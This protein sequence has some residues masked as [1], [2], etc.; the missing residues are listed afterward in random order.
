M[1]GIGIIGCG[2]ISQVR[3]IPEYFANPNAKIIG[4]FDLAKE[5]AAQMAAKYGGK[6]FDTVEDLLADPAI[7]AVS[8]CVANNMHADV[9]IAALKAGKHVLC[10][11]PM[12]TNIEDCERMVAAAKQYGRY[13][14]IGQNQ[15]F[16]LAHAEARKLIKEGLIGRVLSFRTT[17]G[18]SGP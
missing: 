10:E 12:A 2:K 18:H 5:R 4:Y 15:R 9:T 7:D 14:M 16:A 3:H 6:V 17:F 13:L 11:K 1:K 8:V